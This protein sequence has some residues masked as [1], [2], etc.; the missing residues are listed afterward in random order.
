MTT[1][2][3]DPSLQLFSPSPVSPHEPGNARSSRPSPAP[4]S[5]GMTAFRLPPFWTAQTLTEL[6]IHLRERR[7]GAIAA[8]DEMEGEGELADMEG[9]GRN[10]ATMRFVWD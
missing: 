4:T 5:G 7:P 2:A 8:W 9:F 3:H 10:D 6:K 1:P